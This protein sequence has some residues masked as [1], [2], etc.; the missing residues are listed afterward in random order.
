M[1]HRLIHTIAGGA[2][3]MLLFSCQA[4]ETVVGDMNRGINIQPTLQNHVSEAGTR[5]APGANAFSEGDV[6]GISIAQ[7][8]ETPKVGDANHPYTYTS[9]AWKITGEALY[10]CDEK[11]EHT[12]RAYYPY[13]ADTYASAAVSA[14]FD[15]PLNAAGDIDLTQEGAYARMDKA[16]GRATTT[17]TDQIIS[18]PM[19]HRM[20]QIVIT[21]KP[22]EGVES[23]EGMSVE[24]LAP[25]GG[26][27]ATG[28]FNI[29]DGTVAAA[30][31]QPATLPQKMQMLKGNDE[32]FYALVLPG[33]TFNAG[34]PFARI[35][36]ANGK[37]YIYNLAMTGDQK[38]L[39]TASNKPVKFSLTVAKGVVSGMGVTAADWSNPIEIQPETKPVRIEGEWLVIEN[40]T[41]GSLNTLLKSDLAKNTALKKLRIMGTVNSTDLGGKIQQNEATGLNKYISDKQ[42]TH[43]HMLDVTIDGEMGTDVFR[44]CVSLTDVELNVTLS[45]E[46]VKKIQRL[47]DGCTGLTTAIIWNW[48]TIPTATFQGC[49]NVA[50]VIMPSAKVLQLN[51]FNNCSALG[52]LV[53]SRLT[54][55]ANTK[56]ESHYPAS[57]FL[58]GVQ[59]DGD[60]SGY[61]SCQNS[62]GSPNP[63]TYT[64]PKIYVNYS[65]T[66]LNDYTDI[67]KYGRYYPL[68]EDAVKEENEW[69]VVNSTADG[70]NALLSTSVAANTTLKK[71]QIKGAISTADWPHMITFIKAKEITDF[72][73]DATGVTNLSMTNEIRFA[74]CTSLVNLIL[75]NITSVEGA[76]FPFKGCSNLESVYMPKLAGVANGF[77]NADNNLKSLRIVVFP[78]AVL[79]SGAN[80]FTN[81]ATTL[82]KVVVKGTGTAANFANVKAELY[83]VQ[84][85]NVTS[86]ESLESYKSWYNGSFE[87]VHGVYTG[88]GSYDSYLNSENYTYHVTAS[89]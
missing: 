29:M 40:A 30:D 73:L 49:T 57:L 17:P 12:L 33:Q 11:A 20:A 81:C 82:E 54:T 77:F 28:E 55:M 78:Q 84:P 35:K 88:D 65:G 5:T 25:N 72:T 62:G 56:I 3:L 71:L 85:S 70:L 27:A 10:W 37:A 23:V 7:G 79:S 89:E 26:F 16:W 51:S 18:I 31:K 66:T 13:D 21:L 39:A 36:D 52:K 69:L 43:L 68:P 2:V 87:A 80:N 58:T 14:G 32:A 45:D 83:V 42:F 61:A 60:L 22:G 67:S 47:F 34:A 9:S 8:S 24:L 44:S 63:V 6:I 53:I 41:A 1:K 50:T 74:D 75:K 38:N 4:D 46:N 48:G 19:T 64:F 59:D 15:M 86:N 76:G